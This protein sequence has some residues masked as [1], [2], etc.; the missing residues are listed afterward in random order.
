MITINNKSVNIEQFPDGTK[1]LLNFD[2]NSY[3]V[4]DESYNHIVW[5]YESDDEIFTLI[6]L[7]KHLDNYAKLP[8]DLIMP[9]CP[10]GRLDRV[11]KESEVFT[12]KYF[13]DIINSLNFKEVY[14]FDPHSNVTEALI[15]N[16][17]PLSVSNTIGYV[18]WAS[19]LK[20]KNDIIYFPDDGAYKRYNGMKCF[21]EYGFKN[22]IYGKKNRDWETGKINGLEVYSPDGSK[23]NDG[24][25][26]GKNVLMIDDIISY[27]GTLAYSADKLKELG[28][29]KIYIY[30]SHTENSVLDKEKSTLL[31]RLND[32]TIE[33]MYTTNSIYTGTHDKIA[34]IQRF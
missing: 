5:C 6:C 2:I 10:N 8:F 14:I 4:K 28:A 1:R 18:F 19:S 3:G 34:L 31:P 26:I 25:L 16:F 12:L 29:E 32:G 11:K 33:K 15:N 7:K 30:A 22:F 9:Y 24:D 27:G 23:L 13:C 17:R 20:S 21:N